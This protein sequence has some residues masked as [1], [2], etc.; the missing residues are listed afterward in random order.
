MTLINA[1]KS[2][3]RF[4]TVIG[5]GATAGL[6]CLTAAADDW[7]GDAERCYAA[8]SAPEEGLE[9]CTLAIES[10]KLAGENLAITYS[11][12]ANSLFSLGR[13]DDALADYDRALALLPDDPA[14]LSNRGAALTDMGRYEEAI[15]DFDRAV[16]IEPSNVLALSNRCWARTLNKE[17]EK[18]VGDCSRAL[19]V[20]PKDTVAWVSRSKAYKGL[21]ETNK[22]LSDAHKAIKYGPSVWK[23]YY[24]R[25]QLLESLGRTSVAERDYAMAFRLSPEQPDVLGKVNTLGLDID[26]PIFGEGHPTPGSIALFDLFD[27]SDTYDEDEDELDR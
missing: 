18:A 1:G 7:T 4:A 10:G 17:F 19:K 24:Y 6:L 8:S 22:A 15:A 27:Y 16:D 12:R 26:P 11:N 20:A 2:I 13:Y 5:I 3:A 25:G 9:A 14:T 21:G 23:A